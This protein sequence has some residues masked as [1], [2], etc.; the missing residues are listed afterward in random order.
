[1]RTHSIVAAFLCAGCAAAGRAPDAP[2][3]ADEPRAA[4]RLR[5]DLPRAHDCEEAFDLA[6]YK[7]PA[8]DLV[9]WDGA[10]GRCEGREIT[11]RY[12]PRRASRE[13]IVRAATALAARVSP[14][15]ETAR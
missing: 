6:I 14:L 1:M 15:E 2:V 12:L 11:I 4:L 5:V 7:S 9:A 3:P 8:V 10:A 13:E